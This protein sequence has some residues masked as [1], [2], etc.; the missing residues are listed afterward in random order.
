MADKTAEE[1]ADIVIDVGKSVEISDKQKDYLES[2]GIYLNVEDGKSAEISQDEE[3]ATL[4][5]ENQ[6]RKAYIED[7]NYVYVNYKSEKQ[8][9]LI[10]E[11]C[12][13][14]LS[15]PY[16]VFTYRFFV[17]KWPELCFLALSKSDNYQ[18]VGL[19]IGENKA[20]GY[21]ETEGYIAMLVVDKSQRRKGLGTKLVQ[22]T[23]DRLTKAGASNV[24]LETEESNTAAWK[25][26]E[27]MGFIRDHKHRNYYLNGSGAYRMRLF[28][29][30]PRPL[31]LLD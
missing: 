19:I 27:K 9:N 17:N 21:G 3:K 8:M 29:K 4:L 25:L 28:L 18:C 13:K 2:I 7:G 31:Q 1:S 5:D 22:L 15:E 26:Y 23:V 11:L 16:S 14:N 12:S 6:S 30:S 24:M 20:I 10:Q